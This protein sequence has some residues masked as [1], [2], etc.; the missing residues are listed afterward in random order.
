MAVATL[1][2]AIQQVIPWNAA[3]KTLAVFLTGNN[4]GETELGNRPLKHFV[5]AN[6]IDEV[7]RAN[8]RNW[9]V[10]R[11][12]E[13]AHELGI[14]WQAM[15]ARQG[16]LINSATSKQKFKSEPA[17]NKSWI[18]SLCRRFNEGRCEIKD[19]KHPAPYDPTVMLRHACSSY[20]TNKKQHC[21]ESHPGTDH[22]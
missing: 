19:D 18:K 4:F 8:A 9:E 3:F 14:H 7:L 22:R 16:I 12:F 13:S 6:F 2:S 21:L 15:I 17:T 20:L 5:L 1:D 10:K 11:G